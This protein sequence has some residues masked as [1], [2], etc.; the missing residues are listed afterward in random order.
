MAVDSTYQDKRVLVR[1][2]QQSADGLPC[3][4][5]ALRGL[6]TLVA[7]EPF[8]AAVQDHPAVRPDHS[9]IQQLIV[10][11]LLLDRKRIA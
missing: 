6:A 10:D 8:V 3:H 9:T 11:R 5:A 7:A 4:R 1:E 2:R